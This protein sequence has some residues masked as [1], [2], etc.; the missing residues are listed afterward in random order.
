[1]ILDDF[2]Q[3]SFSHYIDLFNGV[4]FMNK[5]KIV[6][7]IGP[8]C[9]DLE[10]IKNM[11]RAG[12]N[13]ARFNMS[14]GTHES[15]R[16]LIN[17]VKQ[18]RFEMASPVAIM[19]D[20]RGPEI[21]IKQFKNKKV[22]LK[23][24]QDF[25]LTT[26]NVLGDGD[27]VSVT[28]DKL[29]Q[30]VKKGTRILLNDGLIELVVTKTSEKMVYTKVIEGGELSNNKSINLPNVELNMKYLSESDKKDLAFGVKEGADVF[31]ISF[32]NHAEDVEDV[33]EFLK[34]VGASCPF[35]ISKIESQKGV[36]NLDEIIR[37]SDG[38]MVARGDMG[39][40][41]KFEKLPHIQKEI[42][43]KAKAAGKYSITATQMLESMI[44]NI[45]PTRAEISD[46][47][48]AIYDGTSAIM[49]SGETSAGEH[50][51]LAVE[52]MRKIAIETEKDIDYKKELTKFIP[53]ENVTCA[54]GYAACAMAS[55][56]GAKAILVSTTLGTSAQNISRFRPYC[57]I[58]ALTPNLE[59]YYKLGMFWGVN[60]VL[61][62]VY[63]DT[64]ELL[65][66]AEQ[67]ALQ[68]EL[69]REGDLVIQTASLTANSSGSDMLVVAIID[70]KEDFD[71]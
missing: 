19:I 33:R 51:V 69:V 2:E 39:V 1:M 70:K 45:R 64:D 46:I 60:P 16:E 27:I 3:K 11:I 38:V 24:G 18:A 57:K 62:K 49:L 58:V 8:S 56:L 13:V 66:A 50:P 35:I 14:H 41:I 21:R 22:L 44:S 40:E 42:I 12:M 63:Y 52:T 26:E 30:I 53:T 67:R 29:P 65:K 37:V 47:A 36:D 7:T 28:Y 31:S 5:T 61:E 34:S 20:T 25:I 54:V 6:C 15:H 68:A 59:T 4:C 48:N 9:S 10:T 17:I 43:K 55:S 23:D 71:D 32:V